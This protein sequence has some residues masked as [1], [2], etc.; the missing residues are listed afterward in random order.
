MVEMISQQLIGGLEYK[1]KSSE[2]KIRENILPYITYPLTEICNSKC[3]F[4]GE[5]GEGS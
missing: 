2:L 3:V 4:C 1:I 5:G